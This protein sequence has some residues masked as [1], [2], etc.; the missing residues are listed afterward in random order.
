MGVDAQRRNGIAASLLASALFGL[1]FFL[2]GSTA[3]STALL[4][5]ARVLVTLGAFA[6]LLARPA[7]RR[8]AREVGR[9]V[10]A[11][12]WSPVASVV[13]AA[14]IGLQLWLFAWASGHGH[15]LEATLGYLL[16][17]LALAAIGRFWFRAPVSRLQWVAIGIAVVAVGA[18]V[19]V[20]GALSWVTLAACGGY[21]A[22]FALRRQTGLD[23][24]AAFGVEI[25]LLTPLALV[26]LARDDAPASTADLAAV[27]GAGLAGT[28]A[29]TSY[30]AASRILPMPVFGL[31]SYVEPVLLFAVA[32]LLGERP[33]GV[34][35]AVYALLA[36]ALAVLAVDGARAARRA[37]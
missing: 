31:L 1:I 17:P 32:L 15:A 2:S 28:V 29:M 21:A 26:L 30:L 4:F 25:V 13:L 37:A 16:L 27:L 3:A 36:V 18:K 23:G 20:D 10:T 19:G 24:D 34:D 14:L 6:L 12:W 11:R 22:Y 33:Q 8:A 5:G 7:A 35:V 9:A